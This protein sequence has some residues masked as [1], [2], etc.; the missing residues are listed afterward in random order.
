[1]IDT[2]ETIAARYQKSYKTCCGWEAAQIFLVCSAAGLEDR[3]K[4]LPLQNI[5]ELHDHGR[6]SSIMSR[7]RPKLFLEGS[8]AVETRNGQRTKA[9]VHRSLLAISILDKRDPGRHPKLPK[10]LDRTISWYRHHKTTR[11]RL[12]TYYPI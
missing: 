7:K 5:G 9:L 12:G 3:H 8:V 10:H 1:M 11:K 2:C 6:R 4:T